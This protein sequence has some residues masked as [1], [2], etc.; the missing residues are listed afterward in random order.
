M[1]KISNFKSD[2][3]ETSL[4]SRGIILIAFSDVISRYKRTLFGPF[5][6]ILA[7]AFGS[8]GI[9]LMWTTMFNLKIEETI[10]HFTIG[11]L[12]WFYLAGTVIEGTNCFISQRPMMLSLKVPIG[13]YPLLVLS[14]NLI[15]F[16]QSL[17]IVLI[18][19]LIFPPENLSNMLLFIPFLL[20]VTI[21]IYLTIFILGMIN[22]RYRDIGV[23]ISSIMPLLF[24]LSP[25]LHKSD[26]LSAKLKLF[27]SFNPLSLHV[28]SLRDPLL[29]INPGAEYFL[30]QLILL[31]IQCFILNFILAKKFK[32][33]IYWL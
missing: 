23:L 11:F 32:N 30:Y 10:P 12:V 25:V 4:F 31:L 27:L 6:S 7:V 16:L 13:C 17:F 2:L 20:I 3:Y 22:C 15:N 18:I 5:W 8:L 19:N 28:I 1:Q 21:N 9:S 26:M 33:L 24:F 14:T 29:G